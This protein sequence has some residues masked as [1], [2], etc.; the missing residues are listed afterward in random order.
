MRLRRQPAKK[1]R[2]ERLGSCI[3]R[4]ANGPAITRIITKT[5]LSTAVIAALPR[6]GL[7]SSSDDGTKSKVDR[8]TPSRS[9]AGLVG[10][11]VSPRT[12]VRHA[13]HTGIDAVR[14]FPELCSSFPFDAVLI[15]FPS[16]HPASRHSYDVP[17][18]SPRT[19]SCRWLSDHSLNHARRAAHDRQRRSRSDQGARR[20]APQSPC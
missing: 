4:L 11:L 18:L 13:V 5:T 8:S 9:D 7:W 10:K 20:R 12:A 19:H 14:R 1:Q 16:S 6:Y 3:A 17:I 2:S 15:G